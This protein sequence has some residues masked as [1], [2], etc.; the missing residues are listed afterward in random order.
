[1]ID[2][3]IGDRVDNKKFGAGTV[4]G[5][6]EESVSVYFNKARIKS[7]NLNNKRDMDLFISGPKPKITRI[8]I[9]NLFDYLDYDIKIN[10]DNDVAII[11]APNGCGKTTIFKILSFIINPDYDSFDEISEIPF[12]DFSCFL[13]SGKRVVLSRRNIKH[14]NDDDKSYDF[15]YKIYDNDKEIAKASISQELKEAQKKTNAV[16]FDG[17]DYDDSAVN[18]D[19]YVINK[20]INTIRTNLNNCQCNMVIDF[21]GANRLEKA[22]DSVFSRS[23][24]NALAHGRSINN[25]NPQKI[26]YLQYAREQTS[27]K[28]IQIM[29]E[30]NRRSS[31]AKNKLPSLY[32]KAKD[33]WDQNHFPEFQKRWNKYHAELKKFCDIGIL[34]SS[35]AFLEAG[36]LEKS[37]A[38]KAT[39]L[40]TYLNAF[41]STLE[42][43]QGIYEKLKLFAD[44][45]NKR[46]VITQKTLKY[47][48]QGIKI[49][50]H[51]KEINIEDLSSG[52]KNDFIMF[53]RLV[54]DT[55]L[56][57][58]VLIDEPEISLHIEW[59]EEYL[60]K[61]IEICRMNDLQAI[62]ATHSP[63]ILN[64][65]I[66]LLVDKG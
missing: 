26:D 37:Y 34:D 40:E 16:I 7:F 46:N 2:F 44:I 6:D 58:I 62:V 55:S 22:Y 52:E 13:N 42:P 54:F 49:Y 50:S 10:T 66:D 17:N 41:E 1:M 59:Q 5:V 43:L 39:F 21:I 25:N 31:E 47:D 30:Y 45:F 24:R 29:M 8:V 28:I 4:V 15:I 57:G 56:G 19:K 61:L 64:G 3:K 9:S 65:H 53:Y 51:G 38:K 63:N 11:T 27:I 12:S 23:S 60:D 36:D 14:D 18:K 32:V 20:W 35:E 33:I 48:D